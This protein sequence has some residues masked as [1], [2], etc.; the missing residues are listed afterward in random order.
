MSKHSPR[1]K[2][3][4]TK[5]HER[6]NKIQRMNL[7]KRRTNICI[8]FCFSLKRTMRW[9]GLKQV[10]TM[11]HSPSLSPAQLDEENENGKSN[12]VVFGPEKAESNSRE[13]KAI[14]RR[15]ESFPSLFAYTQFSGNK[16]KTIGIY[17]SR[18]ASVF[19]AALFTK[20]L[21]VK[22]RKLL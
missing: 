17:P 13:T 21:L 16:F 1:Q 22:K 3:P 7:L 6:I 11:P 2:F 5:R 15:A 9:S 18:A 8:T 10:N 19:A 20:H 12:F 14:S 4:F